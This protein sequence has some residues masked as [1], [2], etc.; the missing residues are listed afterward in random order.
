MK[1]A[2]FGTSDAFQAFMG[3]VYRS[4]VFKDIANLSEKG[5]FFVQNAIVTNFDLNGLWIRN[6]SPGLALYCTDSYGDSRDPSSPTWLPPE[7]HVT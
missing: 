1:F 4:I 2:F 5:R 6:M 3:N 7:G